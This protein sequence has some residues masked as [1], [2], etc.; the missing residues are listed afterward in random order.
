MEEVQIITTVVSFSTVFSTE[1]EE[2]DISKNKSP[3]GTIST[4]GQ[5]IRRINI[6]HFIWT[7]SEII[8]M[9]TDEFWACSAA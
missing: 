2:I 4:N 7:E 9:M 3:A 5:T 8:M 1:N 6:Y